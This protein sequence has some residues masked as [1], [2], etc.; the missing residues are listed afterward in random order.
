VF[1]THIDVKVNC[2]LEH[3]R[4]GELAER[5]GVSRRLLRSYEEQE[6]LV[7]SRALNG[8]RE[9]GEPARRRRVA[10]RRTTRCR[11][12]DLDQFPSFCR[13]WTSRRPSRSRRDAIANYLDRVLSIK[14]T[15]DGS[16][17]AS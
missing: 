1:N 15:N 12:T 10:D 16:G 7:P 4:I 14:S 6:L 2:K 13:V 3:M 9:Y 17:A 5:T 11:T 8:Y